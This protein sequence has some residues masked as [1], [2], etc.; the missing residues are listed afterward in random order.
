[1]ERK[2]KTL[3]LYGTRYGAT[4]GTSEEIAKVLQGEGF[5]VV[6]VNAKE[7]KVKDIS[8]YDLIVVGTGVQMGRWTGE[9]EDFLKRHEQKLAQKKM[10]FFV[11]SMKTVAERE[12]KTADV[13]SA[14]K[15]DIDNKLPK[16]SFQPISVGFFG[17]VLNYNKMNFLFRK[18]LGSVREQV[19]KDGFVEIEPGVWEL[20]DWDEIRLWT[21]EL[22]QKARLS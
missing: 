21:K 9:V 4:A 20:R 3:I 6:V 11:S 16:Y 15:F 22:A 14:R 19:E 12:G 2:M 8:P 1:M 13:E 10:A 18:T 17:G 5:D 7:E